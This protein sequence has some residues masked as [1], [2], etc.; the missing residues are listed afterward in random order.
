MSVRSHIQTGTWPSGTLK[1]NAPPEAHLVKQIALDFEHYRQEHNHEDLYALADRLKVSPNTLKSLSEG[2]RWPAAITIMRLEIC[3]GR[4]FW[5]KGHRDASK[6]KKPRSRLPRS[7]S[8][9]R[10]GAL[11]VI[12]SADLRFQSRFGALVGL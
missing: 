1:A 4:R 8:R 6:V 10:L 11:L 12:V 3:S 7:R 2:E 9:P 5:G